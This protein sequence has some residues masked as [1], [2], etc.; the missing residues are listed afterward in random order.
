MAIIPKTL[1]IRLGKLKKQIAPSCRLPIG[2]H[3]PSDEHIGNEYNIFVPEYLAF[4]EKNSEKNEK[5]II[6][7]WK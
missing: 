2:T 6:R 3:R 4:Y 7:L 1:N 5:N